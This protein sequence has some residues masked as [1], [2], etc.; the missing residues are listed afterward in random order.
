MNDQDRHI[1]SGVLA[2]LRRHYPTLC[3]A[4]FEELEPLPIEG[5]A[6]HLR[7]ESDVH[8]DYLRRSCA[9]PFNDAVRTVSGRLLAVRFLG[10]HDPAPLPQPS[11]KPRAVVEP[12]PVVE[13]KVESKAE[14]R[15]GA[16]ASATEPRPTPAAKPTA[17]RPLAQ[18][19]TQPQSEPRPA[20]TPLSIV[21][22]SSAAS[23]RDDALVINPDYSFDNFIVGSGNRLANAAAVA[24]AGHPGKAYNPFF[25]HGGVGLGKTHLLQAICVQIKTQNPR[26]VLYYLSCESF[27]TRFIEAVR[28]GDMPDFRHRFRDVDCLVI[29]D[30]HFLAKADRTQEEFFH[31]FN[32]LYQAGKQIVLSSDAPPEE[33]PHL[34]ERLVSRF[35]WGLVAKVSPPDFETRVAIL[36]S[37]AS[38]RGFELP[39]DVAAHIATKLNTNIRELEGAIGKLQIHAAVEGRPIDMQ[40][41]IDALGDIAPRASTEPTIQSIIDAV[42]DFYRVRLIELQSERRNR[43]LNLPRQVCM[44]LIRHNTRHSLEEIGGYFGNRDHTTVLHSIR[45]IDQRRQTEPDFDALLKGL[46]DKIGMSST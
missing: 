33:I 41:A 42:T 31:T 2:Y 3:R 32:S 39:N 8:R 22:P 18:P 17:A 37:K 40:L 23:R 19:I 28:S 46:E 35:K 7:A 26:A 5:G 27:V 20:A 6:I 36:K 12:K 30:I 10:P 43:S 11:E 44:Y 15:N 24:V 29:D 13:A 45:T 25:V 9:D 4:W 34:E 14:S 1:W 38:V 21:E 16:D